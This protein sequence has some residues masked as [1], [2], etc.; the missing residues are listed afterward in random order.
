MLMDRIIGA[1]MFKREVYAEVK[2]DA[3]FTPTAWGIVVIV[4]LIVQL[5]GFLVAGAYA[6][7]VANAFGG[8]GGLGGYGTSAAISGT[9]TSALVQTIIQIISFAVG[10]YVIMLVANQMFQAKATFDGL[11][12]PLGLA[13]VWNIVGVF[14]ILLVISPSFICLVGILG[15]AGLVL[16]LI[17]AAIAVKEGLGLD[18]TQT[19]ITIVI[20]GFAIA[21][22]S[23]LLVGLVGNMFI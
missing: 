20:A 12:R 6:A 1:F 4:P 8:F 21:I 10:V 22:V 7:A 9:I 23:S 14:V 19:L 18:W 17:S 3:S 15:L 13:Y 11:V 5:A 2:K 16:Y